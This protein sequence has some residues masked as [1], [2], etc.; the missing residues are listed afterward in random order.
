[1]VI[2]LSCNDTMMKTEFGEERRTNF[3]DVDLIE[4]ERVSGS[5]FERIP[6]T[7]RLLH[8]MFNDLA[9]VTEY[10][11]RDIGV[12]AGAC[13]GARL[14]RHGVVRLYHAETSIAIVGAVI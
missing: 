2:V 1:M 10:G 6:S 13:F 8:G 7:F 3:A 5:T 4:L 9:L 11:D 12:R 14:G